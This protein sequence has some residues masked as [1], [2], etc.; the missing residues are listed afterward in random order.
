MPRMRFRPRASPGYADRAHAG[1]ALV[2][3]LEGRELSDPVVLGLARGGV[4]VAAEV[5]RGL[6]APLRVCVAR[7]IGAP[8]QPELALGAV[9][10][11]G[12][13]GYD[14]RLVRSFGLGAV[15][16]AEL[17]ER[18]RDEA[19]HREARYTHGG[20]P[21][22]EGR[23]VVLVDDGL[24]TGATARAAIGMVRERAPRRVVLAVPVGSPES[25]RALQ[26]EA[27]VV[28]CVLQPADFAA[29][30]Q[31]YD[32]FGAT[33]DAEIDAILAEFGGDTAAGG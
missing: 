1:R 27:D 19:R 8:G 23:D 9:T 30:G 22:L 14:D 28:V 7:K 6:G 2:G 17:T 24:A 4:P 31:W 20:L 21:R 25:V 12:P 18:E 13:P 5:A 29:V 26:A 15:E 3:R 33:T 10:A 32:E 16:L 11:H